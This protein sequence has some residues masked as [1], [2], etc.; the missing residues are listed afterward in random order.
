MDMKISDTMSGKLHEVGGK[1]IS[2]YLC[3]VTYMINPH[4]TCAYHSVN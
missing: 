3:G 4:R 1:E 2:I